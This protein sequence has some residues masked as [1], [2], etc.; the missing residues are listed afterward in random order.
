MGLDRHEELDPVGHELAVAPAPT[1]A[2]A[3]AIPRAT[4][5]LLPGRIR[6]LAALE[7]AL[8]LLAILMP[9]LLAGQEL[10]EDVRL[11]SRR[12]A[13]VALSAMTGLAVDAVEL[14][15]RAQGISLS[16]R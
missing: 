12:R 4:K 13:L 9:G 8:A 11:A 15:P 14:N 2:T 10:G 16:L 3:S 1:A 5:W 7:V 6:T